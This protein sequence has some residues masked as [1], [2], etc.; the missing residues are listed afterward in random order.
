MSAS[1]SSQSIEEPYYKEFLRC[2]KCSHDFEYENSSYHPI[3]LPICGHTMCSRCIR[4][5]SNQTK[6]SQDGILFGIKNTSIVELPINYPL[7]I[8]LDESSK[9]NKKN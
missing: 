4:E 1:A 8:L 9:V 7:L 2:A 3:T 6:C 5:I